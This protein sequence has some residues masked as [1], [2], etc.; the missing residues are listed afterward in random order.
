LVLP[1]AQVQA[2]GCRLVWGSASAS[3]Y[4][5]ASGLVMDLVPE[6]DS[7][8]VEAVRALAEPELSDWAS[9]PGSKPQFPLPPVCVVANDDR[10]QHC[11]AS[12]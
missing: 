10:E 6:F 7:A 1:L 5:S 3:D 12:A 2:S 9:R 8:S 4:H 11:R